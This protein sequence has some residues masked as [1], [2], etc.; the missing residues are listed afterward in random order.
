[1]MKLFVLTSAM[2]KRLIAKGVEAMPAVRGALKKGTL[3]IVAG[4][5]NGYVAEEILSATGQIEGF[6]RRGFRR[7]VTRPPHEPRGER[8]RMPDQEQFP[9][10]VV[11][12]D[13]AWQ[14][15]KEIFDV[16][17]GMSAGDVLLKGANAVCLRTR[18]A[19]V[20][21][22]HPM[23]GTAGA[24][25][26]AVAGRRVRMIVPVG[27]EKRVERDVADLAQAV[28]APD[29]EGPRLLPLPGEV[30]TELEALELLTGATATLV[31]AGGVSGAE[32]AVWLGVCGTS[33]QLAAATALIDELKS[34]PPCEP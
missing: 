18:K 32:G 14:R 26:P 4:T 1:M 23:A 29:G 31:A 20:L 12:V 10:D 21:V 34:E 17:D 19:A 15:G 27:L 16:V 13:G 30:F 33:E 6:T 5:T 28:N 22:G 7:G 11:L 25:I 24:A 8:G 2:G 9:G 3:V